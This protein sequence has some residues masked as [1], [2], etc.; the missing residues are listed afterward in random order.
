MDS[1]PWIVSG[2]S[3]GGQ[4][5]LDFI[6]AMPNGLYAVEDW[7]CAESDEVIEYARPLF[8]RTC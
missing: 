5:A 2:H 4:L 6:K 8:S 3:A 7:G 1:R